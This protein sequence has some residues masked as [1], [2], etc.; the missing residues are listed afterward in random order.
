M[1]GKKESFYTPGKNLKPRQNVVGA[2]DN[3]RFLRLIQDS[4][5]KKQEQVNRG[6]IRT[7]ENIR[8]GAVLSEDKS[9]VYQTASCL[10]LAREFPKMVSSLGTDKI[11][12]IYQDPRYY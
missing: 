2:K 7:L 12:M 8:T 3:F 6:L 11:H 4:S 1:V 10:K 5:V 9:S